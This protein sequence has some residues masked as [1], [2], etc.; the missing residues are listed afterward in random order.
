MKNTVV[1]ASFGSAE[2]VQKVFDV[3]CASMFERLCRRIRVDVI[4]PQTPTAGYTVHVNSSSAIKEGPLGWNRNHMIPGWL[5]I[6]IP[7]F[8]HLKNE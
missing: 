4:F 6:V 1:V 8:A 3:I 2:Y 5:P 7:C